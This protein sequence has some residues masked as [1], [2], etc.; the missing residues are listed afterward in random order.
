MPTL[1]ESMW[2]MWRL[3]LLFFCFM[4][5]CG[6]ATGETT[7]MPMT[8]AVVTADMT[9]G[10]PSPTWI[11]TPAE[12]EMATQTLASLEATRAVSLFDGLGYR[13]FI[14]QFSTPERFVRVQN[15]YVL[16]EDEEAGVQEMYVDA[17]N[18]LEKWLLDTGRPHLEPELYSFLKEGIGQ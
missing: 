1:F 8:T 15:G 10:V 13:G 5:A 17:D 12:V 9:S 4:S 11:L 2:P 16:I 7:P 3:S 6:T 14:I 18:Q